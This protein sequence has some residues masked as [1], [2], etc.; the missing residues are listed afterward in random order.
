VRLALHTRSWL[1]TL[2]AAALLTSLVVTTSA[3]ARSAKTPSAKQRAAERKKLLRASKRN[4]RVVLKPWFLKKA[5]LF[6]LDLPITFRLNPA[7]NQSGAPAGPSDDVIDLALGT[8]PTNP[9]LPAGAG[10]GAVQSTLQGSIAGSLRFS[11]DPAG[12]GQLGTV[13][14]GFST[15]QMTGTP[16]DLVDDTTTLGCTDPSILKTDDPIKISGAP[17]SVGFMNLFTGVF[18][19]SVHTSFAFSSLTRS[20]CSD[21]TFTP[22][23][24]MDGSGRPPLPIRLDGTFRI[25]P[26]LTADGRV[27]LGKLSLSGT[28]ADSYVQVHT[29][30]AGPPAPATCAA[31]SDG[32]L[33][34]RLTAESFTAELLIGTVL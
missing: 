18:S 2:L 21:P 19:M 34:G 6:G 1:A 22:T 30:T 17:G 24:L 29:C 26:A 25:S 14:L 7:G 13:E 8:D 20:L 27:R 33:D 3:D 15:V 28:Q 31:G 11:Q 9:P 23:S 5:S 10:P 12:Y 16:F 32:M 4:P